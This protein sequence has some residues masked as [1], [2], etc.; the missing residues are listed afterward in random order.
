MTRIYHPH[1]EG[2]VW[3]EL[4]SKNI[5]SSEVAAVFGRGELMTK[6]E[7][8][9]VK[10]GRKS[11]NFQDNIRIK[12][13]QLL[14]PGIAQM[15]TWKYGFKARPFKG[16]VEMTDEKMGASFDSEIYEWEVK[17]GATPCRFTGVGDTVV[18]RATL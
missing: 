15:G 8:W 1:N 12:A 18:D 16:Y 2:A 17:D 7:L 13:G 4:R 11:D 5:N 9:E 3:L 10:A 6:R 14:E